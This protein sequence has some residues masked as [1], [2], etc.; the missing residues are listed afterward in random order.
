M[1][2]IMLIVLLG[3]CGCYNCEEKVKESWAM[4]HCVVGKPI[5]VGFT[6]TLIEKNAVYAK[7]LVDGGDSKAWV[8]CNADTIVSVWVKP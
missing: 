3:I 6:K 2:T 1:K 4:R 8:T 7:W 5:P